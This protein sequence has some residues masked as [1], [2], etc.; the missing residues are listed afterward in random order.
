MIL[1]GLR[2]VP[3]RRALGDDFWP[4]WGPSWRPGAS[5]N[6]LFGV[7]GRHRILGRFWV[8]KGVVTFGVPFAEGGT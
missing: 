7:L 8:E 6:G 4:F 1:Q 5:K 2:K 3:S